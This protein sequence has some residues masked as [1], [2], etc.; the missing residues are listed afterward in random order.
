[1][2]LDFLK[3]LHFS[4]PVAVVGPSAKGLLS[5]AVAKF[6]GGIYLQSVLSNQERF[7]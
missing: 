4:F 1:M 5:P 3:V 6:T 7:Y 2:Y